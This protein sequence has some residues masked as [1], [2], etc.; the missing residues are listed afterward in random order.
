MP[1]KTSVLP[2]LSTTLRYNYPVPPNVRF[3]L[4][5]ASIA[6]GK[7]AAKV[8]ERA[9]LMFAGGVEHN[10][11]TWKHYWDRSEG[12]PEVAWLLMFADRDLPFDERQQ[13]VRSLILAHERFFFDRQQGALH[14]RRRQAEVLWPHVQ[15]G[16]LGHHWRTHKSVDPWATGEKMCDILRKAKIKP[17]AWGPGHE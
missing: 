2:D 8:V 15:S 11:K 10:G 9:V 1:P 17:P 7:T 14:P 3:A 13:E 5:F 4:E 6:D 16:Q 12:S